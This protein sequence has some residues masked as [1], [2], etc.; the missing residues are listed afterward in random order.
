MSQDSE[1]ISTREALTSER[2]EVQTRRKG[3]PNWVAAPYQYEQQQ[4]T[5]RDKDVTGEEDAPHHHNRQREVIN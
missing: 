3:W 1:E 5:E 2:W 4:R